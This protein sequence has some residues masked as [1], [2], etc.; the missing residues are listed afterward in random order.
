MRLRSLGDTGLKVSEL[1]FG[2]GPISGDYL[3]PAD[4]AESLRAL[5]RALDLGI[6]F[7]DTV[8]RQG[9]GRSERL[10]GQAFK[11]KR[12]KVIIATKGGRLPGPSGEK[13]LTDYSRRHIHLAIE[14]SL[15]RLQS[16]YVDLYQIHNPPLEVIAKGEVFEVFDELKRQGKTRF[17]GLCAGKPVEGLNAMERGGFHAIQAA[18]N[19]LDQEAACELLPLAHQGGVGVIARVPLASGLLTGIFTGDSQW[20]Q[21]DLRRRLYP[22]DRLAEEL[23]KID[24][25]KALVQRDG[26]SL[27]QFSLRF[28]LS[29]SLISTVI[30]GAKTAAELEDNVSAAEKGPLGEEELRRIDELW[31][32]DF[33]P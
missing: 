10:I 24:A 3:G 1:G 11:G 25:L 26:Q 9:S 27:G 20:T 22:R 7:Y 4:D 30:P 23:R 17:V 14:A 6:N 5:N 13:I 16:D 28:V 31:R 2:G 29:N 18:Y 33:R 12:D 21:G 32:K 15:K 19:L 8:D